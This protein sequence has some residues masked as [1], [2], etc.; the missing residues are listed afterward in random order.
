MR[1][2]WIAVAWVAAAVLVAWLDGE[3]GIRT[4]RALR[5]E[6]REAEARLERL[7]AEVRALEEEVASFDGSPFALERAI[8]EELDWV[9]P[10]EVLVRMPEST[11][12]PGVSSS[13]GG[14]V[15]DPRAR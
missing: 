10:G 5:G 9:R 4:A 15:E 11:G 8:R 7:R 2:L 12:L 13:G 3:S 6:V 14:S 1:G